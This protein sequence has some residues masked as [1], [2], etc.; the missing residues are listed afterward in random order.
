MYL[1]D[2]VMVNSKAEEPLGVDSSSLRL[3]ASTRQLQS[4]W[5]S[6]SSSLSVWQ[7]MFICLL[8]DVE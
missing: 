6:A 3:P 4:D 1:I 5:K 7:S 8:Y 2:N